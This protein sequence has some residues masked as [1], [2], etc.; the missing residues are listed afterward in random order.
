MLTLKPGH[1]G[2]VPMKQPQTPN[3]SRLARFPVPALPPKCT[4]ISAG[5]DR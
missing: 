5:A 2:E 3:P 4:L 1:G